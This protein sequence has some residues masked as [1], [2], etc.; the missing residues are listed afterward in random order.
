MNILISALA[1]FAL[2]FMHLRNERWV[3]GERLHYEVV[4]STDFADDALELP[5]EKCSSSSEQC[6][7][8]NA[9]K[10]NNCSCFCGRDKSTFYEPMWKC[11][12][13]QEVREKE[14]K[15]CHLTK[16]LF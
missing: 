6:S 9:K 8:Y 1:A 7:N 3:C 10:L 12:G 5:S 13:N 11:I 4:R 15:F 16:Y 14:G 2:L